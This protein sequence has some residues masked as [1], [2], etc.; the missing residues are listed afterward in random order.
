MGQG[1]AFIAVAD[2]ATAASWNPAGLTQLERP[3]AS[4]AWEYYSQD[5]SLSSSTHPES[6]TDN[7]V[8]WRNLNYASIVYPLKNASRPTVLSLNYL[9]MYN[10]NNTFFAPFRER[11]EE[12]PGFMDLELNSDLSY[13]QEGELAV[14]AP[15]LAVDVSKRF[16][17]GFTVNIWS[18][19]LTG[20]SS[21]KKSLRESGEL[22]FWF[23]GDPNPYPTEYQAYETSEFSVESGY[24]FVIGGMYKVSQQWTIGA[25]VKPEFT[26]DLERE[27]NVT[28]SQ[29]GLPDTIINEKTDVEMEFPTQI[30]IGLAY[31]PNDALTVSADVFWSDWS[32]FKFILGDGT[33]INPFSVDQGEDLDDTVSVRFGTEYL[34]I[35][36]DWIIPFRFGAAYDPAPKASGTDDY[37]TL[38]F[39]TGFQKGNI[40]FDIAYQYRW[41]N[42]V[43][44][45]LMLTYVDN[46][47]LERHRLMAS[48]IWYF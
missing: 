29:T 18:D 47:D 14:L 19:K 24:S 15:S 3:E 1:N 36:R 4:F 23:A 31:R 42:E 22:I 25:V 7:E 40:A 21:F 35:K 10:F 12:V 20:K 30:G 38:S 27:M 33:N 5:N 46:E 8:D 9:K 37:F 39:G 45:D 34:L 11:W 41:G 28:L 17:I 16:T 43:N 26:L 6:E 44:Q 32:S 13:E 2:D 48:V